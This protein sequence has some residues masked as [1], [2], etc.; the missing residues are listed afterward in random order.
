M[1]ENIAAA[2]AAKNAVIAQQGEA[3]DEIATLLETKAAGNSGGDKWELINEV[4]I[5]EGAEESNR[6]SF[7]QDSSG[8]AFALNKALIMACFPKY[9]GSS[10][11]PGFSF[12][13]INNRQFGADVGVPLAYTSAWNIPNTTNAAGTVWMVDVSTPIWREESIRDEGGTMDTTRGNRRMI[14]NLKTTPRVWYC[15]PNQIGTITEIGG[16]G[17]LIYPGCWFALYGVRA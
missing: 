15:V 10:K 17:M 16:T 12:A 14:L 6:I 4:T 5:A 13:S 9:T 11:I 7:T 8:N 3:L 2:I 1:S